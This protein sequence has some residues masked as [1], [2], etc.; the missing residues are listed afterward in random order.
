M[1]E[2]RRARALARLATSRSRASAATATQAG[3]P[4]PADTRKP[5]T[6]FTDSALGNKQF[7][8]LEGVRRTRELIV[9]CSIPFLVVY[10]VVA[11]MGGAWV[12]QGW[13]SAGFYDGWLLYGGLA[14]VPM[15]AAWVFAAR[16]NLRENSINAELKSLARRHHWTFVPD[17]PDLAEGWTLAPFAGARGA[18]VRPAVR[19]EREG[20]ECGAFR[21]Q[22]DAGVGGKVQVV[23][24]RVAYARLPRPIPAFDLLPEGFDAALRRLLGA[25]DV[26]F[27]S[28]QFNDRWR[29]KA[30]DARTAHAV[31]DPRMMEFLMNYPREDLAVR[32]DN[33]YVLV[34]D[35]GRRADAPL[36]DHLALAWEFAQRV[37]G[38]LLTD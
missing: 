30:T 23:A 13:I 7:R 12:V 20:L 11:M 26:E 15:V 2:L 37:P 27:E 6:R 22:G 3:T 5:G 19:G 18:M 34:W 17:A 9:V 25:A 14:L 35:S 28:P 1:R 33:G 36:T 21:F 10:I 32:V 24:L 29:V 38:H 16:T 31:L 4:L 8:T